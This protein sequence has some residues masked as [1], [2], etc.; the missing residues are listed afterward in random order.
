MIYYNDEPV[1]WK[2]KEGR[3]RV[4][5]EVYEEILKIK[6]KFFGDR[7]AGHVKL[8]YP[9][10]KPKE[11]DGGFTV[12]KQFPIP[13]RSSDGVWRYSR[14]K[15]KND[16]K[17]VD[18]HIF[19]K[20][21]TPFK[22]KDVEFIWFLLNRSSVLNK[23]IFIED[24][25]ADASKEVEEMS[26]DADIR[27]AIMG[28]TS[29]IAKN[30]KMLREVAE[31]FSVPDVKKLGIAQLKKELYETILEGEDMGDTFVNFEKFEELTEGELKRKAAFNA[32]QAINDG[33]VGF[34][35]K[36]WWIMHGRTH[37]EKLLQM[38]TSDLAFKEQVL[39]DEVVTNPSVRSRLFSA[40]G[41]EEYTTAEEL[42]ELD[43][44]TLMRKVND[45]IKAGEAKNNDGKES[46]IKKLCDHYN[47]EFTPKEG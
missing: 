47:I 33:V 5:Q 30:E 19:I 38:K 7:A 45:E 36:A 15:R 26:K 14:T 4:E 20:H 9:K 22:E 21:A 10:G 27:Y 46:L 2:K 35:D 34:K 29:P 12:L 3:D 17:F 41:I 25:E 13:L 44:P 37:G 40:L 31:I 23:Y 43:R 16:G 32:R 18:S 24:L 39:I 42:W 28:K 6:E 1:L 11:K 8:L